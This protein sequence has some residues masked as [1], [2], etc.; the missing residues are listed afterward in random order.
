[1]FNLIF[2]CVMMLYRLLWLYN[3]EWG[4]AGWISVPNRKKGQRKLIGLFEILSRRKIGEK[5][6]NLCEDLIGNW[7]GYLQNV[8]GSIIGC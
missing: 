8:V 4:T 1:L 7:S 2:G 5:H 3:I 6:K